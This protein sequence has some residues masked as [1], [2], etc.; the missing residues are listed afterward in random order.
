MHRTKWAAVAVAVIALGAAGCS[1]GDAGTGTSASP[2][3]P[4]PKGT[5]PLT[6]EVVR[7]DL[8]TAAADAG[9]PATVP[10]YAG[11]NEDAEAGSLRSCGVGFK[12]VGTETATVDVARYDAVVRELRERDWQPAQ[13][14][15][16]RKDKSGAIY[17]AHELLK[18]RGWTMVAEYMDQGVGVITLLAYDDA[19]M[20]KIDANADPVG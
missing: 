12:G 11:V 4:R 7:T 18:Q 8:D 6:K 10:E 9:A 1:T 5:G 14:P 13:E 15:E 20:K 2:P 3:S 17:S 16:K 19:C